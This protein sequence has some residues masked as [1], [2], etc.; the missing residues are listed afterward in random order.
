MLMEIAITISG[1]G[2]G[3]QIGLLVGYLLSETTC[4]YVTLVLD[5]GYMFNWSSCAYVLVSQR[6][7]FP[8]SFTIV[9]RCNNR[10]EVILGLSLSLVSLVG[11]FCARS[12]HH[13]LEVLEF[14]LQSCCTS[15]AFTLGGFGARLRSTR[16]NLLLRGCSLM[17]RLS[18]HFLLCRSVCVHAASRTCSSTSQRTV[19]NIDCFLFIHCKSFRNSSW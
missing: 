6:S 14:L 9:R 17:R 18:S 19:V 2:F 5:V 3:T 1:L 7:V 16:S 15:N 4:L 12:S 10:V 11:G 8:S 13:S